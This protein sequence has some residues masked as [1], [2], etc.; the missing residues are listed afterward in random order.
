V[1]SSAPSRILRENRCWHALLPRPFRFY[2]MIRRM[3][4]MVINAPR[5]PLRLEERAVPVP[6]A[7]EILIRVHACGVC[8]TDLH[9]L[10][11]E[12]SIP[13]L[14]IVA[15]VGSASCGGMG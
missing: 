8:R 14:P 4:A 6:A 13:R 5:R 10:D 11:G 12:V 2:A 3:R 7:G 15:E 9:L 1:S